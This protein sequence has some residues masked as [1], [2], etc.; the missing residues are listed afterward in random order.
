LLVIT[1]MMELILIT[2]F[3]MFLRFILLIIF[4]S[5]KLRLLST[6]G[7]IVDMIIAL[8]IYEGGYLYIRSEKWDMMGSKHIAWHRTVATGFSSTVF[9]VVLHQPKMTHVISSQKSQ[10]HITKIQ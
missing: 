7:L 6:T 4:G 9:L 5:E 8:F 3:S 1:L 10:W 2:I